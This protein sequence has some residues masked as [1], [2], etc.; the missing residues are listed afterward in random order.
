VQLLK[1]GVLTV[2]EV[3]AMRGMAP[4][5]QEAQKAAMAQEPPIEQQTDAS[6]LQM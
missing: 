5:G 3:R 2:N 6:P 4:L 1:A